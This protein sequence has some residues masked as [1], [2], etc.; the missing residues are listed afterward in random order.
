MEPPVPQKKTGNVEQVSALDDQPG[1]GAASS[2]NLLSVAEQELSDR[3]ER[4]L[5][6]IEEGLRNDVSFTSPVADATARYL[7]D[8]GGKRVRP[9]LT[10][11]AAELGDGV[12]DQVLAAARAIEITHLASLYHDDVMDEA[13]LRRGITSAHMAWSNNVAILA[14]D[15]LFARASKLISTLGARAIELQADTFERLCLGQ[16]HETVG[17]AAGEDPIEHYLTV[18]AD[19]TGSLISL[20]AQMGVVFSNAPSEFE[21]P[22]VDYGNKLGVAFQLIDDVIDLSPAV[23]ETGKRAGTDLR[24]GVVTLPL[25]LLRKSAETNAADAELLACI[26]AEVQKAI[27]AEEIAAL[28]G[29]I[30]DQ[31]DEDF[32]AVVTA[33]REHEVT[34]ETE[35]VAERWGNEAI[36]ALDQLP[37]GQIKDSLV[38]LADTIIH[39]TH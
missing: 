31:N 35:R 22:V 5:V 37:E 15:L 29:V 17:P 30:E 11:L 4:N 9:R 38:K 26:D 27:A 24:A 34:R 16:L 33:L 6:L 7:L 25:L 19:K 39:R 23:D 36:A 13:M 8:A 1:Q 20:S 18:L 12:N 14:G 3:V 28:G 2:D 10:L 32:D 21:Q